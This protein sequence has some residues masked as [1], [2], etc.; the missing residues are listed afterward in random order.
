MIS[1][2]KMSTIGRLGWAAPV[3]VTSQPSLL[4]TRL[5][6]NLPEEAD[7]ELGPDVLAAVRALG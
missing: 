1:F 5:S 3:V 4:V 2:V 6:V 7:P